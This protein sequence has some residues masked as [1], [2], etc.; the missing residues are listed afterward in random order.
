MEKKGVGLTAF[1]PP[2]TARACVPWWKRYLYGVPSATLLI[3][4]AVVAEAIVAGDVVDVA[5]VADAVAI[6]ARLKRPPPC[7]RTARHQEAMLPTASPRMVSPLSLI[8][9]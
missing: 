6:T 4:F 9:I 5:D 2:W 7:L 8:H 1:F 3:C